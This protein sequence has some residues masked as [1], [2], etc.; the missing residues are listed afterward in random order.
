M[1]VERNVSEAAE[2]GDAAA[3]LLGAS[4][5]ELRASGLRITQSSMEVLY[6]KRV[7]YWRIYLTMRIAKQRL[8]TLSIIDAPVPI[9]SSVILLLHFTSWMLEVVLQF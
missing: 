7:S 4:S 1:W 2:N 9:S 3:A 6:C 5:F 8:M